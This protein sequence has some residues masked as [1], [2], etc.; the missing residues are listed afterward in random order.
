[1]SFEAK[2]NQG[3]F[4]VPRCAECKKIVWPAAEFCSHCFGRVLLDERAARGRIIEFSSENGRYF[5][6]V[7]I[8]GAFRIIASISTV[9]KIGQ[10][11]RISR[12]GISNGQYFFTV[13]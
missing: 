5:C 6:I 9:P 11:V 13:S 2:L 7:E 4:C 10:P 8:E 1:M 12:C 3:I